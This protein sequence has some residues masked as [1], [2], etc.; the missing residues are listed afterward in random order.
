MS[1]LQRCPYFRGVLSEGFHCSNMTTVLY[2]VIFVYTPIS[3]TSVMIG[4]ALS[5]FEMRK[6]KVAIYVY[7][8]HCVFHGVLYFEVNIIVAVFHASYY[9]YS[10]SQIACVSYGRH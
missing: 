7:G 3:R 2:V 4:T 10:F 9:Y 6:V 5:K 1:F 8:D